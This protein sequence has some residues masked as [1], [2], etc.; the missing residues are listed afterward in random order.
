MREHEDEFVRVVTKKSQEELS[1]SMRDNKR[2]L[3][4]AQA[5]IRKLDEI[6]RRL[7]EDN[8]EG[9]ITDERFS[10]MSASYEEEQ[11]TL[12]SRVAE[13]KAMIASEKERGANVDSFLAIV[14]K[15]MDIQE[16][17]AEIIREFVEKVYVYQTE[18]VGGYKVQRI[19][20]VWKT[21]SESST[22]QP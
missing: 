11:H 13:L 4:Q 10:R 15:Y 19:R 20:I 7:Y 22:C 12:E 8:I 16:L 18:R 9:K 1:R 2:E 6:I 14:R 5:R 17:T 3:E 21:V